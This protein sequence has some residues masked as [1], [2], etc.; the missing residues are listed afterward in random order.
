MVKLFVERADDPNPPAVFLEVGDFKGEFRVS[1]ED[2]D[3]FRGKLLESEREDMMPRKRRSRCPYT[4]RE[5]RN[6]RWF[7]EGRDEI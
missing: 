3:W 4:L 2:W 1:Q 5:H 6:L 7:Y